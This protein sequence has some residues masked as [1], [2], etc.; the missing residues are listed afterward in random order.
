MVGEFIMSSKT[1]PLS[2]KIKLIQR[3]KGTEAVAN[4]CQ[5]K[6]LTY[7][8]KKKE[9]LSF[10]GGGFIG[11]LSGL[12]C[13]E[14][15]EQPSTVCSRSLYKLRLNGIDVHRGQFLK[16]VY[17]HFCK[18]HHSIIES[19]VKDLNECDTD[20]ERYTSIRELDTDGERY[21]D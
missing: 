6:K 9:R 14:S 19:Y 21:T 2:G 8:Q 11:E 16:A 1:G 3:R 20:G 4:K 13:H 7:M 18:P 10:E 17:Q 5:R 12:F 15:E